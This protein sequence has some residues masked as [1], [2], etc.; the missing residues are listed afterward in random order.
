MYS[1]YTNPGVDENRFD[2]TVEER[3]VEFDRTLGDLAAFITSKNA[4]PF[5]MTID[6]VFA[7]RKAYEEIRDQRFVTPALVARLYR[8]P[9]GDVVNIVHFEPAKAIKITLRRAVASG[10]P[11]D[12][13]VYGAQQH[14]PLMN[15]RVPASVSNAHA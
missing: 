2:T 12:T 13:D 8:C 6:I 3:S 5:L 9:V 14:V 10:G 7:T 15:C 11:G 4:G 1:L